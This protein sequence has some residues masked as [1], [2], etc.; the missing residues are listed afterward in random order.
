MGYRS[1]RNVSMAGCNAYNIHVVVVRLTSNGT[2]LTAAGKNLPSGM[3]WRRPPWSIAGTPRPLAPLP[4]LTRGQVAA[5]GMPQRPQP[6]GG[7]GGMQPQ[8]MDRY[9]VYFVLMCLKITKGKERKGN[10]SS[11]H[12]LLCVCTGWRRRRCPGVKAQSLGCHAGCGRLGRRRHPR[13]W[14]G[15]YSHV[16]GHSSWWIWNGDAHAWRRSG[17]TDDT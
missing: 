5:S 2:W 8:L 6:A 9:V 3:Q 12:S 7:A 1:S 11:K 17:G 14:D 16:R 13:I 15:R 10:I 4:A